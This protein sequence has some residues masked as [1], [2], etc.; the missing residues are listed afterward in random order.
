MLKSLG[1]FSFNLQRLVTTYQVA[2]QWLLS[3]ILQVCSEILNLAYIRKKLSPSK[4]FAMI[5]KGN[6]QLVY[7]QVN[8]TGEVEQIN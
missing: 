5:K 3:K 6:N 8:M 1:E 7:S 2:F 4:H